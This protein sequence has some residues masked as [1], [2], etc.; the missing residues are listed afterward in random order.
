MKTSFEK[1]MASNAVTE[2]TNVQLGAIK[3]ELGLMDDFKEL[4]KVIETN[5]TQLGRDIN[6]VKQAVIA[7][8]KHTDKVRF[9]L[10]VIKVNK[11]ELSILRKE[12]EQQFKNL[13]VEFSPQLST[14]FDL[15]YKMLDDTQKSGINGMTDAKNALNT[16]Y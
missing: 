2:S 15:L 8:N 1:F 9:G 10:S 7:A 14:Q 3:V 12:F 5:Y 6:L 16:S 11:G 4:E 13:G